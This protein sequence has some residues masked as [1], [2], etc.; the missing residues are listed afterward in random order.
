MMALISPV[1]YSYNKILAVKSLHK[2]TNLNYH[3]FGH[4]R[5]GITSI[6]NE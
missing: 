5:E 1:I 2:K 6:S 3:Y 4:Y